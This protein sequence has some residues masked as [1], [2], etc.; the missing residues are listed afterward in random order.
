MGQIRK[1]RGLNKKIVSPVAKERRSA[2]DFCFILSG[3]GSVPLSEWLEERGMA[4]DECGLVNVPHTRDVFALFHDPKGSLGYRG[5]FSDKESTEVRFSSVPRE[6]EPVAWMSF[7]KD[8]YKKYCR[9]Y[10]SYWEWV[11]NRNEARYESNVE[12]G[13]NYDAKNL[14][15]TMRLL[16]MAE[17]IATKGRV[18]VRRPN[19]EFL[20]RI[21]AGEF[22]YDEL[23]AMAEKK[24]VRIESVFEKS[25][26][27]NSPDAESALE[28]LVRIR[29]G[30]YVGGA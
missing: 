24:L 29:E 28:A 6:A 9:E 15:H 27:P 16:D 30:W 20:L 23:L 1:A 14:M 5:I 26:L 22:E 4:N 12:H 18:H 11:E 2:M 19:R 3:Q 8:G 17:E 21:R 7:N 25:S 10:R 13:K